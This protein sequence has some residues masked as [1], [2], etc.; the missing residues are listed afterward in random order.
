MRRVILISA[1]ILSAAWLNGCN[2]PTKTYA[3]RLNTYE[4]VMDTDFQQLADDWDLLWLAN[5][6][7]RLSKWHLR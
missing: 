4:Q 2:S 5:R 1:M 6:Q 3:E 7:Y